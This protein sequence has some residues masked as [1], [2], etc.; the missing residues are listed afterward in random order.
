MREVEASDANPSA[1]PRDF[2]ASLCRLWVKLGHSPYVGS[3][4]GFA[5]S[6]RGSAIYE[7][8]P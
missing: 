4:S 5:E 2:Q 8:A 1:A 7:N 3:M 6:G